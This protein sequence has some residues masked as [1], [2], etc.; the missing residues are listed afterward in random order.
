MKYNDNGTAKDI[1]I[2]AGDTL[3][4]GTIVE[5]DGE[6][7]PSGWEEIEDNRNIYSTDER[8]IGVF[9]GKPL[10]RKTF[11]IGTLPNSSTKNIEHNIANLEIIA[12]MYGTSKD[13]NGNIIMFPNMDLDGIQ[14]GVR[15]VVN[16]SNIVV[17]TGSNKTPFTTSYLTL[18]YTKTTDTSTI[19]LV[20]TDEEV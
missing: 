3:P 1:V 16:N 5:Y 15:I 9:L 7:I 14:Y 19:D 13:G 2:K 10:Y 6:T 12:N 4:V 8:V 17:M 20:T 11:N 18:E